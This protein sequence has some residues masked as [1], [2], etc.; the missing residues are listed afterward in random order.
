MSEINPLKPEFTFSF[1]EIAAA[2]AKALELK[3]IF[4]GGLSLL[5]ALAFYDGFVYLAVAV[6]GLTVRSFFSSHSFFPFSDIRFVTLSARALFSVGVLLGLYVILHGF[7]AIALISIEEFRGN[8]LCSARDG[9]RFSL[10]R[11]KQTSLALASIGLFLLFLLAFN[12]GLGLLARLPWIGPTLYS[13]LF[14]VPGFLV[15]LFTVVVALIFVLA[16]LILPAATAADRVGESFTSIVETFST[17]L[18][19][20]FR[21]FGYTAF[22]FGAA[23]VCVWLLAGLSA[24]SLKS[25]VWISGLTGGYAVQATFGGGARMLPLRGRLVDFTTALWPGLKVAGIEISFNITRWSKGGGEGVASLL[26]AV[27]LV[28]IFA[29]VWG[30]GLSIL[31]TSQA[32]AYV[33]IRKLRDDYDITAE[34]PQFLEPEWINPPLNETDDAVEDHTNLTPT[35]AAEESE[36][37]ETPETGSA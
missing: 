15:A 7:L 8:R 2:P 36:T 23:K 26:M 4:I 1:R 3:K 30:Y 21:W 11:W 29:C 6:D 32:V 37:T 24:L 13:V 14:V 17:F 28:I 27:A 33:I 25:F 12:G 10:S 22:S 5:V 20:P 31:A 34:D 9:L 18:R 16:L 19:Q 35:E